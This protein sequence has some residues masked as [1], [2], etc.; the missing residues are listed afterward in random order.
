MTKEDVQFIAEIMA[1]SERQIKSR[2][3]LDVKLTVHGLPI[4]REGVAN[5]QILLQ[6]M[7]EAMGYSVHTL[8]GDGRR[9]DLVMAKHS[10]IHIVHLLFPK[11]SLKTIG[12]LLGGKDHTSVIYAITAVNNALD[13][14]DELFL[15][16]YGK[17][18]VAADKWYE[19]FKKEVLDVKA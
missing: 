10:A 2:L 6:E 15:S 18:K 5:P 14:R 13:V 4:M 16:V 8:Q 3:G 1:V 12:N 7:A 19:N 9:R 11:M 17:A